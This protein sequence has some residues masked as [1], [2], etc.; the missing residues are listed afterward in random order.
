VPDKIE[1]IKAM[2]ANNYFDGYSQE[3]LFKLIA[4]HH[5]DDLREII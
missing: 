4:A 1:F 5:V 2:I 3:H